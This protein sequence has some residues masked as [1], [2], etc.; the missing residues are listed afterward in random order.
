MSKARFLPKP[1]YEGPWVS[2]FTAKVV[3]GH[4]PRCPRIWEGSMGDIC[5]TVHAGAI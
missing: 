1:G 4:K 2:D 5:V 3:K